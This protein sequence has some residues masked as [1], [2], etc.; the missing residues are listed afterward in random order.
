MPVFLLALVAAF[1]GTLYA[2][3]AVP[4]LGPS[5][6]KPFYDLQ[7]IT[8]KP[9]KLEQVHE[10][11]RQHQ[12]DVLAKHGATNLAY[13]VPVGENPEDRLLCLH[14]F[15]SLPAM[16]EFSRALKA[17]PLWVPL[18]TASKSPDVRVEK[19]EL[20]GFT[21]TDY[22]PEFTPEKALKPRVFEL[23]T[24]TCPSHDHL[25][26]LHERFRSHT[27]KLFAKHGM[28]NLIYW[29]PQDLEDSDRKLVYLLA[30]ESQAAAKES[31]AAFGKDPDWTAARE[32]S[33]KVAGGSLTEKKG[34]VSEFFM[35]TEYSPL[36]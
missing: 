8:A 16:L 9:G 15:P 25:A 18:D 5:D 13:L 34:V 27:V 20:M 24:Y 21:T 1:S 29:Q 36:R 2:A 6:A 12:Q 7:L 33:E 4:D 28:Q 35:A 23:R 22:S 14:K 19:V 30:H 11:F 3:D 32:A 31:F 17:D 10:W 26:L